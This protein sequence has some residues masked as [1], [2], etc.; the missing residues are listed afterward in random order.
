MTTTSP[1]PPEMF[2]RALIT[3]RRAR[4]QQRPDFVTELVLADIG[5]RVGAINRRFERAAL[6]GPGIANADPGLRTVDSLEIVPTLAGAAEDMPALADD[7]YD[8]IISVLDLQVVNDVPGTLTRLRR[9]LRPDGFFVAAVIG[10]R[11]LAELRAAWIAADSEFAGGAFVRVA[12]FMDVRDAGSLLQR[13]GFALP[14]SDAD[15]HSVRYADALKLMSELKSLGA[16]NPMME[17]P[18]RL[19][20]PG[21]LMAAVA[22]YPVDDDGRIT[23]TLEI[24]WM[25]GWAPDDSQ[26]KPLRRGSAVM[27]LAEALRTKQ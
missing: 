2:D 21:Q 5:E 27:S 24:I 26:Q 9:L 15:T 4:A 20:T 22:A 13:A 19:V 8:L 14:V 16:G 12:P 17:K 1:I 7:Q 18:L 23:A 10:G 6:I 11:S 25:S 3:R